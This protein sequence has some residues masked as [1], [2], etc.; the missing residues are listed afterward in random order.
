MT[1]PEMKKSFIPIVLCTGIISP[2][3]FLFSLAAD[4]PHVLIITLTGLF[5]SL[6]TKKAVKL[7]DRAIIYSIVAASVTAVLFDY[8]FPMA[9]DRFEYLSSLFQLN[10]TIPILFYLAVAV[11]FFGIKKYSYAAASVAAVIALAFG[12]NVMRT[13]VETKRFLIAGT[14]LPDFT[15]LYIAS[16]CFSGFFILLACRDNVQVAISGKMRKYRSKR[17]LIFICILALITPATYGFYKLLL[18]FESD[19]RGLQNTLLN[20][21]LFKRRSDKIVFGESANLNEIISPEM[22]NN[23]EQIVIRAI[24]ADEPGYLRGKTYTSYSDGRWRLAKAPRTTTMRQRDSNN[25]DDRTFSINKKKKAKYSIEILISS[26]LA[27]KVLFLPGNFTQIDIIAHSLEYTPDGNVTFKDWITDGGYT[28]YRPDTSADSS[29]RKPV[30]PDMAFYTQLPDKLDEELARILATLPKL[31][32]PELNDRQRIFILLKYFRDN[33]TYKIRPQPINPVDPVLSFLKETHQGHCELYATGMIVLLRRLGIPARYITGFI[34]AERH[35]TG[36]YYV[37]RLGNA[38]A[39]VEAFD[40]DQGRW[41]LV[42][43]TP[44]SGALN[45]KHEWSVF[46]SWTDMMKKTFQ[47]LLSNMRRGYFARAIIEFFV[48]I[49]RLL[50]LICYHSVRGP[51]IAV[52]FVALVLYYIRRRRNARK[53][54]HDFDCPEEIF[55]ELS[56]TYRKIQKR[57][58]SKYELHLSISSTINDF[59]IELSQSAMPESQKIS[60]I[61]LLR[62][63]EAMRYLKTP[64]SQ[65]AYLNFRKRFHL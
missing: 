30:K 19:L 62:E 61:K 58:K 17:M 60:L 11:T 16:I 50:V 7:N 44:P 36:S 25:S 8:A 10:I 9:D 2:A 26:K 14:V 41:L 20:P 4:L 55:I 29:W 28:I 21:N 5:L 52:L 34:C 45:Y 42:D 54:K 35:P 49:W 64:P 1:K 57:L 37:A 59:I 22:L 43:P 31:K 32:N 51:I 40:R 53:P 3:A 47:Q 13:P 18:Y 6:V 63:Y 15:A 24:S 48:A 46:E 33:F 23:Q 65:E 27:S 38:H 12:S 56:K 39:W